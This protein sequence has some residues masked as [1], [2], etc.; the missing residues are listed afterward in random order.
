MDDDF[1]EPRFASRGRAYVYV[2]PCRDEDLLKVG[3]SR[4]PLQRL[5]TLHRR[6]FEFFDLDRALLVEADKVALARRIERRLLTAWPEHHAP[7]PLVVP[8]AAAGYTEWY[9]GVGEEVTTLAHQLA[10]DAALPVHQPLRNWLA[11]RLTERADALYGWSEQMLSQARLERE[12]TGLSGPFEQA[13]LDTLALCEA[14]GLSLQRWLP[15]DV[16]DWHRHGP[17]RALFGP[18]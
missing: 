15:E 16:L 5:R 2:L 10:V 11:L 7:A 4:E 3:F 1:I 8:E 12:Y 14:V 9:R 6:F 18:R 13:L 17:H